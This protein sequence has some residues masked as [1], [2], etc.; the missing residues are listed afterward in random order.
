MGI[1][2]TYYKLEYHDKS[3]CFNYESIDKK[4]SYGWK[5]VCSKLSLEQCEEFTESMYS[6]YPEELPSYRIILNEFKEF[7]KT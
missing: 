4:D 7:L 1:E 3:N 2:T 6:K 5:T